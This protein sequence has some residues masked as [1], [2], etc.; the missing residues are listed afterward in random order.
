MRSGRRGLVVLGVFVF[1]GITLLE[2]V[3]IAGILGAPASVLAWIWL[4]RGL[5]R[6]GGTAL[7][8][9]VAGALTGLAG[10]LSAW[11]VQLAALLGPGTPGIA[12]LGAGL[13]TVGATIFVILWPLS[14]ALVCS[15]ATAFAP[16]ARPAADPR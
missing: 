15:A 2:Q 10:A 7:D 4:G 14:G 8:G 13:G 1:L 12:R 11:I 16:R 6:S 5:R 3:P 9:A